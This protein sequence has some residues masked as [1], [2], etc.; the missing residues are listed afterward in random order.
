MLLPGLGRKEGSEDSCGE[1]LVLFVICV[2]FRPRPDDTDE[3]FSLQSYFQV[4][5]RLGD[6]GAQQELAY[7]HSA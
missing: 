5:A 7:C 2:S 3:L 4:A 6:V 1:L